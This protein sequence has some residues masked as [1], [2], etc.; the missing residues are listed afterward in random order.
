MRRFIVYSK[1]ATTSPIIKDLKKAGRIDILIHSIIAA[2]FVSN[3][4]REDVELHLLLMGPP[5]PPKHITIRY[6]K[7]STISKK[8]LKKLIEIA[9]WK[10]KKGKKFV[11]PGVFI[12]NKSIENLIEEYKD[13]KIYILDKNGIL[14]KDIN[15][16]QLKDSVFIIGDHKGFEKSVK[17]KLKKLATRLSLGETTYFTSQSI[18]ILNYELDIRDL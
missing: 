13:K 5:S 3:K 17:K 10:A 14:I 8:D 2:L 11:M 15:N 18:V 6:D 9:L 16:E 1:N 4:F 12:D 7:E